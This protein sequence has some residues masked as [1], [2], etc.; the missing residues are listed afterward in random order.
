MVIFL[1][2]I[3]SSIFYPLIFIYLLYR[4]SNNKED[5]LR[6]RE[7]LGYSK[8]DRPLG[9]LIWVHAA[10]VGEVQSAIP[11]M[12]EILKFNNITILVSTGTLT[13]AKLIESKLDLNVIHQYLP[14]DNVRAV[15]RF[16][17]HWQPNLILWIESELW[18]NTLTIINKFA[19]LILINGRISDRSFKKWSRYPKFVKIL[20]SCF[21]LILPQSKLD[22]E[23][24]A[25]LGAENIK[26][27]GNL[28]YAIFN[29]SNDIQKINEVKKL[30][31]GKKYILLAASTHEG[32]EELIANIYKDLKKKYEDLFLIIA[33]RHPIRNIEILN[34]LKNFNISSR[35][36]NEHVDELT[37]IYL[38]DTIG[39]LT[40]FYEI[41][42]IAF[43][44]GSF[45]KIGG[46]N[47]LEAAQFNCGIITGP[48]I[49]NFK[50]I[51]EEFTKEKAII[52]AESAEFL[53]NNLDE[54]LRDK[55]YLKKLQH[56]AKVIVEKKSNIINNIME[57]I[58]DYI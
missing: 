9:Y 48:H 18:P 52:V 1:Y 40:L 19:R 53:V 29:S 45:T 14:I 2:R 4:K 49:Y 57:I 33:P 5:H 51:I 16:I 58:N 27:I 23:R 34:Q 6:F 35:S 31:N 41:A 7:R 24:F 44:G 46:H 12:Q 50:E 32:E 26:Y 13:S 37:D 30:F 55:Q 11:L 10:S 15:K 25:I 3:L 22:Q 56:N 38:A 8:I 20:L 28:K 17:S 39:E 42:D 36:K 47:P 43:I 21:T 54:M